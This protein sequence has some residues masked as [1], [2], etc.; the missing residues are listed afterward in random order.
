MDWEVVFSARSNADL[1]QI[2]EYIARDD[3]GAASRFGLELIETAES[4]ART[5]ELGPIL[6]R[7]PNTRFFPV[8]AY[9]IAHAMM[10]VARVVPPHGT[11]SISGLAR[12]RNR[13]EF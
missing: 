9:L 10:F 12:S 8:G 3:P 2:V 7:R 1:R 4:L 6:P 11:A 13:S 5:P